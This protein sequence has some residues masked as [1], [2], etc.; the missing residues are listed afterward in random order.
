MTASRSKSPVAV[1]ALISRADGPL[2]HLRDQAAELARLD[3]LLATLLPQPLSL[4][5]RACAVHGDQLV[6]QADAPVWS[7]RLRLEQQQLLE[8]L[9]SRP[10]HAGLASVRVTVAA[11]SQPEERAPRKA[12]LSAAA[13]LTLAQCADSQTDPA[14]RDSLTRLSRRV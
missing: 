7:T 10:D 9:R 11:A 6:L 5:V 13:A 12:T 8:Q 14:L 3:R 4:H 2:A 1:Q